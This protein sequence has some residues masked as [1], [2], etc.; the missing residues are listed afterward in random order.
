MKR[1]INTNGVKPE[2]Q[3]LSEGESDSSDGRRSSRTSLLSQR[4]GGNWR[5]AAPGYFFIG[6][7]SKE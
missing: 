7:E 1:L 6:E 3:S 5:Y 4:S 2:A